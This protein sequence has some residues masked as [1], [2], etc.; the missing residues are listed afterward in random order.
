MR[1]NYRR[2]SDYLD[3]LSPGEKGKFFE[4]EVAPWILKNHPL[5]RQQVKKVIPFLKWPGAWSKKD[6]GTDLI[7][8]T[9][10]SEVWAVQIKC[11]AERS[12]VKKADIDSFLSD[13]SRTQISR[14]ILIVTTNNLGTN[15]RA[16]LIGVSPPVDVIQLDQL[17]HE[18][19][20][21]VDFFNEQQKLKCIADKRIAEE[22]WRNAEREERLALVR[23]EHAKLMEIQ[24]FQRQQK[25]RYVETMQLYEDQAKL[26]GFE[27]II[28]RSR[29]LN[30]IYSNHN[31]T[32]AEGLAFADACKAELPELLGLHKQHVKRLRQDM[33]RRRQEQL[34][35][36][37][38]R[39]MWHSYFPRALKELKEFPDDWLGNENIFHLLLSIEAGMLQRE[40]LCKRLFSSWWNRN[41]IAVLTAAIQADF[42]RLAKL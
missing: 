12:T 13:T 11:V 19:V 20:C 41:K 22:Q 16:S 15:A 34:V 36:D 8:L 30:V 1:Y 42:S 35:N 39:S 37:S 28:L 21:W 4:N 26:T 40:E 3:T 24:E 10:S 9:H 33:K 18:S 17:K 23:V 2:L 14:R 5:F 32:T 29:K 38:K 7:A 25:L 6:I 31:N 27:P